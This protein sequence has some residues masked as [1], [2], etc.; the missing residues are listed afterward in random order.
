MHLAIL[1]I[2]LILTQSIYFF[3]SVKQIHFSL[4]IIFS[5]IT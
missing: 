1:S 5:K 3:Y 2:E 4:C